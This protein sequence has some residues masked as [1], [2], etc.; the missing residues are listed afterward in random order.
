MKTVGAVHGATANTSPDLKRKRNTMQWSGKLWSFKLTVQRHDKC[1]DEVNA[2]MVPMVDREGARGVRELIS[3]YKAAIQR[4][5]EAEDLSIRYARELEQVQGRA[6]PRM[7]DI[8]RYPTSNVSKLPGPIERQAMRETGYDLGVTQA[9]P[10]YSPLD[11]VR[12]E[13]D[14]HDGDVWQYR[15]MTKAFETHSNECPDCGSRMAVAPM[16]E[17][18]EPDTV[19]VECTGFP[20]SDTGCGYRK[21]LHVAEPHESQHNTERLDGESR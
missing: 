15:H 12:H 6:L 1:L 2:L 20:G 19:G 17:G 3:L 21:V 18:Q 16:R 4:A 14:A 5:I 11:P 9:S 13:A 7:G 8:P 10:V